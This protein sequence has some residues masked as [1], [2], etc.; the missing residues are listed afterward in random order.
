MTKENAEE[1]ASRL[2]EL[3]K[4]LDEDEGLRKRFDTDADTVLTEK[5]F[6]AGNFLARVRP[7][8]GLRML[9]ANEAD[10]KVIA[11]LEGDLAYGE[12]TELSQL[13]RPVVDRLADI[14]ALY[15]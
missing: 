7:V 11:V 15:P 12:V 9:D 14:V 5:G 2:N 13:P 1:R 8:G 4:A 10:D 6:S 3:R